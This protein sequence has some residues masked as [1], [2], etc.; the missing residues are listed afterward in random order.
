MSLR[1]AQYHALCGES[2]WVA[3]AVLRGGVARLNEAMAGITYA[4]VDTTPPLSQPQHQPWLNQLI[5]PW[6]RMVGPLNRQH[7]T[8]DFTLD[9]HTQYVLAGAQ[10]AVGF[11]ALTAEEQHL[12]RWAALLHDIS[13]TGGERHDKC[14]V[15][16]D[17]QHPWKSAVMARWLMPRLGFAPLVVE[18]VSRLIQFHQLFG[19]MIIRNPEWSSIP[20][21]SDIH[22]A[23]WAVGSVFDL[24]MLYCL[25][26]GDIRGVKQHEALFSD[27][28]RYKLGEYRHFV[29]DHMSRRG[30]FLPL[31]GS[32][33][34]GSTLY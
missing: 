30:T 18:R 29:D 22:H 11:D 12:V 28:V 9:I 2:G 34:T 10:T 16:V 15:R 20:P 3:P 7:S 31:F 1:L 24:D 33:G 26:E 14:A 19:T 17:K 21:E 5:P 32:Q 6:V 13:K 4:Q 25:T 8:H 27:R 23:A